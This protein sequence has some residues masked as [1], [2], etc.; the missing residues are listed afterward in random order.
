[1]I[2]YAIFQGISTSTGRTIPGSLATNKLN[3]IY[4][5]KMASHKKAAKRYA[6]YYVKGRHG[7]LHVDEGYANFDIELTLVLCNAGADARQ[8][9]NAWADGTGKLILSDDLTK[10]YRAT[11]EQEVK[12]NRAAADEFADDF[13]TTV[14]YYTGD[15]VKYDGAFYKFNKAHKGAWAAADADKQYAMINGLFDTAKVIFNCQPFLYESVESE[16]VFT[17]GGTIT[18]PGTMESQP[19]IKVEGSGTC[20]FRIGETEEYYI[21]IYNVDPLDPV[22][23]DGETGYIYTAA[24]TAKEMVGNIPELHLGQNSVVF[25][26]NGLTKLTITPRWRWL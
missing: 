21:I 11:V 26:Q 17:Q 7:A 14:Q 2:A 6:E 20:D 25:G 9:V 13:E 15:F 1:M 5:S 3:N 16:E 8:I 10:C 12:W 24:G 18:N 22:F 4:V 19:L 23:I